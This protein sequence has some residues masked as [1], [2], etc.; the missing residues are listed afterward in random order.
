MS[1]Q[2]LDDPLSSTPSG[3][4]P[5]FGVARGIDPRTATSPIELTAVDSLDAIVRT[6]YASIYPK[7]HKDGVTGVAQPDWTRFRALFDPSARLVKV[8]GARTDAM[9]VDSFIAHVEASPQRAIEERELARRTDAYAGIA[10]VFSSYDRVDASGQVCRGI[11]TIQ[12]RND[13]RRW[14]IFSLMWADEC[15]ADPM[16]SRYLPRH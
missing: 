7:R 1:T 11:N 15:E 10:Q 12:L 2:G 4:S 14:W 13:G 5:S 8:D 3:I 16:P 9:S 6:L